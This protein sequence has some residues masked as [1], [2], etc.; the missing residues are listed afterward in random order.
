M[1][2][3]YGEIPGRGVV[4]DIG[5]N[6]GSFAIYAATMS[7]DSKIIVLEPC[8]KFYETLCANVAENSFGSRIVCC[9]AAVGV[10]DSTCRLVIESSDF[11]YPTTTSSNSEQEPDAVEVECVTLAGILEK[12]GIDFIDLLKVDCEGGEY[13]LIYSASEESLNRV[14][15]IRMEFHEIDAERRNGAALRTFL[16]DRGFVIERFTDRAVRDGFLWA[17]RPETEAGLH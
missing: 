4:V 15:T 2:H 5:G 3:E 17:S 8:P 6:V 10:E 1:K 12:N 16:Q 9:Q 7:S 11:A 14:R 13:D